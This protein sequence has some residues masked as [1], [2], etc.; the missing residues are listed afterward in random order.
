MG[1]LSYGIALGKPGLPNGLTNK[2]MKL[3]AKKTDRHMKA[4]PLSNS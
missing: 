4:G 3:S 1:L 2:R